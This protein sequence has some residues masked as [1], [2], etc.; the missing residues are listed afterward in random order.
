MVPKLNRFS[1]VL[2]VPVLSWYHDSFDEQLL[3]PESGLKSMRPRPDIEDETL[4]PA[5]K[6]LAPR[7]LLVYS[8][9][10]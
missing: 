5:E 6:S 1:E 2:I 7:A 8:L 4:V 10:I 3:A 9:Y